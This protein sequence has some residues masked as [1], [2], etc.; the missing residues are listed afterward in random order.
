MILI[1]G[2]SSH[3]CEAIRSAYPAHEIKVIPWRSNFHEIAQMNSDLI[4]IVGFDYCSYMKPY[5]KYMNNNVIQPMLA[6]QRFAKPSAD[7]VYIATQNGSKKYTFSRYRF[8]KEKLGQ[9]LMNQWDNSY[10]VRF[11]TFATPNHEPLVKGGFI[12]KLIFSCLVKT[13]V[14]KTVD[15]RTVSDCLKNYQASSSKDLINIK[16]FFISIPR[17]QFIDRVMRLFIA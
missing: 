5:E 8:A 4:F 2:N 15:M 12:T 6:V 1:I 3:L 14:V 7:K 13:G 16:G 17:P 11:D 10:V 9:E